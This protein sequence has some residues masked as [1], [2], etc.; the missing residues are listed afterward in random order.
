LQWA[1]DTVA[2]MAGWGKKLPQGEGMGIA[3]HR[4]F[5]SYVA[6]VVHVRVDGKGNLSVPNVYYA[7]DCG[8]HIN[9]ERIRSQ[10]EGAAVQGFAIAKTANITFKNGRTEQSNFND[11][12]LPRISEA[13]LNVRIEI[14]PADQNNP[15]CGIGE[16]AIPPFAPALTNA[17]FAATGKRIRNLPIGGQLAT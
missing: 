5:Q 1:V 7:V 9:P 15:S 17:V 13:P 14:R 16:V 8:F 4:S 6:A 10:F 11:M 3:A 2:E 12:L